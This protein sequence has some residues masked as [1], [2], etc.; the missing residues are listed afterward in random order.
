MRFPLHFANTE[1]ELTLF[2]NGVSKTGGNIIVKQAAGD[3]IFVEKSQ[4][5]IDSESKKNV[6]AA[7]IIIKGDVAPKVAKISNGEVFVNGCKY[8]IIS[9]DR[10]RDSRGNVFSTEVFLK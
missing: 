1:F 5:V 7:Y 8:N 2:D 4:V 9:C 10:I 3:C 6:S